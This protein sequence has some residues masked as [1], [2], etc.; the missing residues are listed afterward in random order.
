MYQLKKTFCLCGNQLDSQLVICVT[1]IFKLKNMMVKF[2]K[3]LII[4]IKIFSIISL[5][6][7]CGIT[8]SDQNRYDN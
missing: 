8:Y 3:S 7:T 4:N 2:E 1:I 5:K 6:K